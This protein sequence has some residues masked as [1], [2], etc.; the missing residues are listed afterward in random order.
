[1]L[2]YPPRHF[3]VPPS[4]GGEFWW[5]VVSPSTGGE[6]LPPFA[7]GGVAPEPP[8]YAPGANALGG[9][10]FAANPNTAERNDAASRTLAAQPYAQ[11][12]AQLTAEPYV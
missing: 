2:F 11:R 6:L 4:S 12:L 1:M 7:T 8:V 3:V 5:R 10:Q 9:Y